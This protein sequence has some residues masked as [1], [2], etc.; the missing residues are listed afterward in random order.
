MPVITYATI[1]ARVQSRVID[2]PSA[3]LAEIPTL[4]NDAV[5]FLCGLHNFRVMQA[6]A[7]YT[8]VSGF[9]VLGAIP[10]DW[11]EPRGM[12]Y[13][14]SNVG[15]TKQVNWQPSREY[16]Y[17]RYAPLDPNQKGPPVDIMLGEPESVDNP[18]VSNPDR[19]MSALNLEIYPYPDGLSDYGDGQYRIKVPY[20]AY[21]PDLASGGDHNWFTDW[22]DRYLVDMATADAFALDWDEQREQFW[23]VKAL[24]Q[25]DGVNVPTLGGWARNLMN[26]DKSIG[27]APGKVLVPRRDVMAAR[28]QWRT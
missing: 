8:T 28:D 21:L 16:T 26:R 11:K 10:A 6:E 13:Y 20:W 5:H 7:D 25:W 22:G 4:V 24:G 3:V 2:L 27:F 19:D 12:A 15:W 23:R 17:R 18:D 14:V 9:H 1:Q